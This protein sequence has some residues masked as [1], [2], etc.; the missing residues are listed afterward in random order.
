MVKITA[1]NR[2]AEFAPV[3]ILPQI[4]FRNTWAW[5]DDDHNLQ[6]YS[7]GNNDVK[8][9]HRD[10]G[11]Y[12]LFVE[13]KVPILFCENETNTGKLYGYGPLSVFKDGI[14]DYLIQ[15]LDSI[16]HKMKGTKA[17][18]N[19]NLTIS[20]GESET[21]RLRVTPK[22]F[23]EPFSKFDELFRQRLVEANEFFNDLKNDVKDLDDKIIQRQK[24]AFA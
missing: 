18:F 15:E 7:F 2:G 4:W 6:I 3:N 1:H 11:N 8:I 14:N 13:S 23:I 24:G 22:F 10:S 9:S 17:A 12:Y 20:S 16:N 19:F 21:I 5:K